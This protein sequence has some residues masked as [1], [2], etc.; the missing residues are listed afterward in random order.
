MEVDGPY[1]VGAV[2]ES[3]RVVEYD[4]L[5]PENQAAFRRAVGDEAAQARLTSGPVVGSGDYVHYRGSYYRVWLIAHDDG[6]VERVLTVAGV[7][8]VVTLAAA[9]VALAR[10]ERSPSD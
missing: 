8:V 5:S 7:G 2:S 4:R 1:E 9:V 10:W 3:D 6:G